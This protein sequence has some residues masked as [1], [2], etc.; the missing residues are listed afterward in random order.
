MLDEQERRRRWRERLAW[1]ELSTEERR[2]RWQAMNEEDRWRLGLGQTG[3]F[4]AIPSLLCLIDSEGFWGM[5]FSG[6]P[7]TGMAGRRGAGPLPPAAAAMASIPRAAGGYGGYRSMHGGVPYYGPSR[8]QLATLY[9]GGRYRGHH[10]PLSSNVSRRFA[11]IF[12]SLV[13]RRAPPRLI[14]SIA[15]RNR[16]QRRARRELEETSRLTNSVKM[17]ELRTR[18]DLAQLRA[19][20]AGSTPADRAKAEADIREIR[21]EMADEQRAVMREKDINDQEDAAEEFREREEERMRLQREHA[22]E[23]EIMRMRED[24]HQREQMARNRMRQQ[25]VLEARAREQRRKAAQLE[26]TDAARRQERSLELAAIHNEE[27]RVLRQLEQE[28]ALKEEERARMNELQVVAAAERRRGT[29]IAA[30]NSAVHAQRLERERL[31]ERQAERQHAFHAERAAKERV[32]LEAERMR[33]NRAAAWEAEQAAKVHHARLM[34]ANTPPTVVRATIPVSVPI[35]T[36]PPV[37]PRT[38]PF[39]VP[40][41]HGIPVTPPHAVPLARLPP[42][43]VPLARGIPP[44]GVHLAR[45]GIRR[46]P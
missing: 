35:A 38:T 17:L 15:S 27:M 32:A 29:E 21:R 26:F 41:Q 25:E 1:E 4:F 16:V 24:Q 13:Q 46:F 9:E 11:P 23:Q 30:R 14:P 44:P 7:A 40:L 28:R 8:D 33:R 37:V 6:V 45:G 42:P 36:L 22:H 5:R 18:L 10:Y 19:T 43:G 12:T 34:A 39:G 2:L 3:V 31:A 20:L